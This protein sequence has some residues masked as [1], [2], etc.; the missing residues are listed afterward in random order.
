MRLYRFVRPFR[1]HLRCLTASF[2][3]EDC[4]LPHHLNEPG[5]APQQIVPLYFH[6]R[7]GW[8]SFNVPATGSG[9]QTFGVRLTAASHGVYR[10]YRPRIPW[11]KAAT[12]SA[13]CS[14]AV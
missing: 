12:L 2:E 9:Y 3:A 13:F 7:K 14:I 8:L 6:L 5:C 10:S 1:W 11:I 4:T